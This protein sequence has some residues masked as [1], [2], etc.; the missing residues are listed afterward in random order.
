MG[1]NPQISHV[2]LP[3]ARP[4]G[5]T[6]FSIVSAFPLAANNPS[7]FSVFK[8]TP[9]YL[10]PE[11]SQN[12]IYL[13]SVVWKHTRARSY[14]GRCVCVYICSIAQPCPTL[15][16]PIDYKP[17]RLLCGIFQ[18][19]I[20]EWVATSYSRGL[21]NPGIKPTSSVLAGGFTTSAN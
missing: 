3:Y 12:R 20:L 19:R 11:F 1:R 4:Q 18:A 17:N 14:S 5:L 21:P 16:D 13:N 15:C 9:V 6:G 7:H 8:R 10:T 2:F